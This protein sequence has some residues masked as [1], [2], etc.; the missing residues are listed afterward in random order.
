MEKYKKPGWDILSII[1]LITLS[2]FT[3]CSAVKDS[4]GAPLTTSALIGP[5]GGTLEGPLGS[6]IEIP[7]GALTVV[8]D[9][10]ITLYTTNKLM[11]DTW[12]PLP[13]LAGAASFGPD[14][15]TFLQPVKI[16]IPV[17]PPMTPGETFP[18]MYL[19][20]ADGI[21]VQSAFTAV[22]NADGNSF[23][24][25][26]THFC[27]YGGSSFEDLLNGGSADQFMSDFIKWFES[28]IRKIGDKSAK[29]NTCF[30]VVGIAY[31]LTFDINGQKGG[32]YHLTERTSDYP[33]SPLPMIDY[34]YEVSNGQSYNATINLNVV[35]YNDCT[36]PDMTLTAEP[37][38]LAPG[39][40][41]DIQA[42]LMCDGTAMT[43]KEVNFTIPSGP[44]EISPGLTTTNS[45][46]VATTTFTAADYDAT[47]KAYHGACDAEK[48]VEKTAL[49]WVSP[50]SLNLA[51]TFDQ[52]TLIDDFADSMHYGGTVIINITGTNADG[53][54]NL[55]GTNT[56]DVS[57]SGG[58]D[59]CTTTTQGTVTFTIEGT[60]EIPPSDTPELHLTIEPDFNTTKT[61]Y[62][63]DGQDMTLPHMVGG[64]AYSFTI[65]MEDGYTTGTTISEG[66][67]TSTISYV[68]S[69]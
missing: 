33:D 5:S 59:D 12:S 28:N 3:D 21:W 6:A 54:A 63:P 44:G 29:N 53:T 4:K 37:S 64:E 57:G 19:D 17:D 24:A 55:E 66:G 51:I 20:T 2:F 35:I 48:P 65:P 14:T 16:T 7:A 58:T 13:C 45:S 43:G 52:A 18:L 40:E 10:S 61:I 67:I 62:C 32:A 31:D 11:P 47:V 56:F 8:T 49:L 30:E 9:I 50:D 26:V 68:L 22:V 39:E 23:S 60:L 1:L 42:T 25:E 41:A 15:T 36:A 34:S 27:G 38:V 46:G 69:F